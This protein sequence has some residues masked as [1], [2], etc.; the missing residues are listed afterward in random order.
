MIGDASQADTKAVQSHDLFLWWRI[1]SAF[2]FEG[3]QIH[4]E[5]RMIVRDPAMA[6][7]LR[8]Q[9]IARYGEQP[10]AEIASGLVRV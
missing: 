1:C 6:G 10:S 8:L 2:Q 5:T 3:E 9:L 4:A 7:R